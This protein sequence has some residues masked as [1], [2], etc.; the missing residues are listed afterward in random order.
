MSLIENLPDATLMSV[1]D[2]LPP[3]Q[4]ITKCPLVSKRFLDVALSP[5][6]WR[7]KVQGLPQVLC[8]SLASA[9]SLLVQ[10]GGP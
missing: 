9:V 2:L 4:V 8:A 5:D 3:L 10:E 6:L 7:N 1:F